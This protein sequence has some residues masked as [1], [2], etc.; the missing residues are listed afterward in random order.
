[1]ELRPETVD[2]QILIRPRRVLLT[3][4]VTSLEYR[5][6]AVRETWELFFQSLFR[7]LLGVSLDVFRKAVLRAF[8]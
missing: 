4:P 5:V 6:R 8:F 7:S 1:M 2:S 3:G